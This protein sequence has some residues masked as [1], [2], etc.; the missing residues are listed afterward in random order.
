[1]KIFLFLIISI[2]SFQMGTAQEQ[3]PQPVN[4][5]YDIKDVDVKP[6]H[7]TGIDAFYK[8][9]GKN[10]KVPEEEGI[11]GK[12]IITFIIETNGSISDVKAL[13]DIGFG[14]GEKMVA[15]IKKSGKWI[16]A[17][18]EGKIVRVFYQLPVTIQSGR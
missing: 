8:F 1:M 18:K 7:S 4:T 13:Q 15:V 14:S 3:I 10:F 9:V 11:K 5:I 6:E 12:I 17:Q 16:P 2:F